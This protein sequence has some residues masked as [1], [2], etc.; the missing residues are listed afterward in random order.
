MEFQVK[1]DINEKIFLR[2]PE[3]SEVGRLM[4]KKAIDLIYELGFEQF[5]FKK[6]AMEINSTEATIYRYFENKHRLLLYILNW[7]WSYMEFLVTFKLEN[8]T[9]KKERLKII[10][11]LL[12]QE[13]TESTNQ[14]DYNKKLLNQIV[15]AESSK[16]YLVKEV[17]E[18]NKNEVFKPYKDLCGKIAEVISE[19]NP[20]YKYPRSLSTT[21]IETSHHQQY[22]S[23]N[24]PK[25]TDVSSKKE[26]DFTSHF[27]QD[28]L[29]KILD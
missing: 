3:N 7:Y 25:L 9:D 23:I 10:V 29:F 8:V 22:F 2:N 18:I 17:A 27:I 15:I 13:P 11:N 19:Y 24:L 4:V 28:F 16:V 20:K 12:T 5:T 6:L 21:L 1:F 14:F 26:L